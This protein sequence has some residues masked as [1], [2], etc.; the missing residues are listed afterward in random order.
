[1]FSGPTLGKLNSFYYKPIFPS[2]P[3]IIRI[4]HIPF[5]ATWL[6]PPRPSLLNRCSFL[7]TVRFT[8]T[9][10][11]FPFLSPILVNFSSFRV[12]SLVGTAL[13]RL[14]LFFLSYR[15]S[16]YNVPL[17][18]SSPGQ[19]N[20]IFT[21]SSPRPASRGLSR[22]ARPRLALPPAA[23]LPI[24]KFGRNSAHYNSFCVHR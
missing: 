6:D 23:P 5:F 3:S 16:P 8:H 10:P 14:L 19:Q 2:P 24:R 11:V 1:L 18:F 7:G 20:Y 13:L 12:R 17:S 21:H 9:L 4:F 22:C 15:C